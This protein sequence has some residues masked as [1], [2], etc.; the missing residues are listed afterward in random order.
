MKFKIDNEGFMNYRDT[1]E[2]NDACKHGPECFVGSFQ[3]PKSHNK[4]LKWCDLYVFTNGTRQ[5]VCIRTG[6]DCGDYISPGSLGEFMV[7]AGHHCRFDE[8]HEAFNLLLK[9]GRLTW[10]PIPPTETVYG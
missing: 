7:R 8:Y 10:T 5:E 1:P 4:T 3:V 2:W 6:N 9:L